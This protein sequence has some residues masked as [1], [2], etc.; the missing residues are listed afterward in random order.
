MCT[1]GVGYATHVVFLLDI[2]REVTLKNVMETPF[3][4]FTLHQKSLLISAPYCKMFCMSILLKVVISRVKRFSE[5]RFFCATRCSV[6]APG[7]CNGIVVLLWKYCFYFAKNCNGK[8]AHNCVWVYLYPC[9]RE[10]EVSGTPFFSVTLWWLPQEFREFLYFLSRQKT[11]SVRLA[12][13]GVI[14]EDPMVVIAACSQSFESERLWG[15]GVGEGASFVLACSIN[16]RWAEANLPKHFV[17]LVFEP[18]FLGFRLRPE[19][20]WSLRIDW[21]VPL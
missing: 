16:S 10:D 8:A 1:Q 7:N 3:F 4:P 5:N 15:Q 11:K 14:V 19:I 12:L 21:S 18:S 9:A 20:S 13:Q 2:D 6:Y 17:F